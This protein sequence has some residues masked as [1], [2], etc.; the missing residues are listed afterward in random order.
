MSREAGGERVEE[1][2]RTAAELFLCQRPH[3]VEH[4]QHAEELAQWVKP[5]IP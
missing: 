3:H 2:G 4:R 5:D 1:R